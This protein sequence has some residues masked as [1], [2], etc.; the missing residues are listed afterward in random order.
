MLAYFSTSLVLCALQFYIVYFSVLFSAADFLALVTTSKYDRFVV[1]SRI[2]R[3]SFYVKR[4]ENITKRNVPTAERGRAL[5]YAFS[6][7]RL[8]SANASSRIR[9][10]WQ[11]TPRPSWERVVR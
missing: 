9:T 10:Q 5:R 1:F 6:L 2:V 8:I 4:E 11:I 7:V 3:V